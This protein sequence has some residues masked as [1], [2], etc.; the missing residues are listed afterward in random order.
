MDLAVQGHKDTA[1]TTAC[2]PPETCSSGF[3]LEVTD[4]DQGLCL[5]WH[6]SSWLSV[7]AL[8]GTSSPWAAGVCPDRGMRSMSRASSPGGLQTPGRDGDWWLCTPQPDLLQALGCVQSTQSC[9]ELSWKAE[10]TLVN[11]ALQESAGLARISGRH[12]GC[13]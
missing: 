10:E 1:G 8:P 11:A 12:C 4:A 7:P 6:I 5:S 3:V 13:T 2:T 9:P